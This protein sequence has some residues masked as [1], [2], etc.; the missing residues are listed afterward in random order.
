MPFT[1]LALF[2]VLASPAQPQQKEETRRIIPDRQHQLRDLKKARVTIDGNKFDLWVMDT[3]SKRMEGMMFVEN[4]DF[5]DSEGMI[6]VFPRPD[7]Q[8]FW[9][10]NTLVPLDIA[11][12]GSD[13]RILNTYT[14]KA[15]D[16][17]TDYSSWGRAGIVI[18]VR[19]GLF[20][21][22]GIGRGDRVEIPKGLKADE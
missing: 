21:K 3:F 22:L 16:T 5:K 19:A 11:Y 18:E 1:T 2:A 12:V 7:Y 6:F 4:S 9:M 14:M 15:L 8:R 17:T 10:K 20:R 13:M